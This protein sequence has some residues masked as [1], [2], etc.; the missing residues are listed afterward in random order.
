MS[1]RRPALAAPALAL[2]ASLVTSCAQFLDGDADYNL[3][4]GTTAA[5]GSGGSTTT[6]TGGGGGGGTT[7]TGTGGATTITSDGGGGTG[8][9]TGTGGTTTTST[10]DT[11]D[12]QN[13]DL[14]TSPIHC[15]A[16]DHG[17][18]GGQC[19][20]GVC[21]PRVLVEDLQL[22]RALALDGTHVYWLSG[23]DGNVER[24]SKLGAGRELIADG[25]TDARALLVDTAHVYWTDP[26]LKRVLQANKEAGAT[27]TP[28][29]NNVKEVRGLARTD[30][31]IVVTQ[32]SP[33]GAVR[34]WPLDNT[35]A[36]DLATGLADPALVVTDAT[37]AHVV[38]LLPG[39]AD[40]Q[41]LRM[42]LD[43]SAAATVLASGLD[44]PR[45]LAND[46]TFVFWASADGTVSRVSPA[47]AVLPIA[48][49]AD[50]ATGV[51]A[52]VDH[53]FWTQIAAGQGSLH[54]AA[55][56]GSGPQ[57]LA[58]G[59]VSPMSVLVDDQAI[60][61]VEVGPMSGGLFLQGK[62]WILAK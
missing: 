57:Q 16:C 61:W 49:G 42:P 3:A 1:P 41:I 59:F 19:D 50:D 44:L 48:S 62:I 11:T 8:D 9:T 55:K 29:A 23:G 34:K 25:Q 7:S 12:C 53:V 24:I 21:Q 17:C 54:R 37:W 46:G 13:A 47:G 14:Q 60:Y 33:E 35:P 56:D 43:G 52:D 26:V 51:A 15:G 40:D 22:V 4:P 10:T 20:G 28:F 31:A 5:G 36:L 6:G 58:S 45:A 27:V 2:A 30:Q 39:A 38:E 18:L 32:G